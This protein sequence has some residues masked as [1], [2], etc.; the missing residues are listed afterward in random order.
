MKDSL[1]DRDEFAETMAEIGRTHMP[2]GKYGPAH[3]PPRGIPLYDLP[4]E[5]LQWFATK[6][7]FPSGRL[8]ELLEIIYHV[9]KDGA[10]EVF[11]PLRTKAG[12]RAK[13]R[14][15]RKKE[16]RFGDGGE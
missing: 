6:G 8:G 2:F 12:G 1:M 11:S 5:Y 13:L 7:G 9:K 3:F 4:A 14:P 15:P 10:D 16:F